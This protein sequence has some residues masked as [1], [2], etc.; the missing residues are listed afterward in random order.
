MSPDAGD[1]YIKQH[2]ND[3]FTLITQNLS[4]RLSSNSIV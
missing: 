4:W 3:A 1:V 2:T